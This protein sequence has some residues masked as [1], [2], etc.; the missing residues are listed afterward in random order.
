VKFDY[1]RLLAGTLN[2]ALEILELLLYGGSVL[3]KL[4]FDIT[5]LLEGKTDIN[6]LLKGNKGS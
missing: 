1:Q 6:D 3:S 4:L 5:S 2:P